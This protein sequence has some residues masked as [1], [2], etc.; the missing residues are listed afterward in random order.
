MTRTFIRFA[1]I[2]LLILFGFILGA[3]QYRTRGWPFGLPV[4]K[5][6]SIG[7]VGSKKKQTLAWVEKL[8]K[9][10][11]ILYFRHASRDA[12]PLVSAFDV[13]ALAANLQDPS[14]VSFRRAVCLTDQG[15]EEAKILGKILEL[16]KIPTGTVVSSP[17][18]RAMQ[19]AI[20]AF[21]KVDRVDNSLLYVALLSDK[22]PVSYT[23]LTLPT[24]LRV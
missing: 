10:G 21:G 4:L 3:N 18:C 13:Y 15:I 9:G 23:H 6:I 5:A 16:A 11:F 7:D 17:S 24:I 20:H 1:A 12:W 19:T 14:L 22:V 2:S 8:R